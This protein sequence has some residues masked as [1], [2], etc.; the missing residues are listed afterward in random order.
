VTNP[1]KTQAIAK[2]MTKHTIL[3]I[4]R[5]TFVAVNAVRRGLAGNVSDIIVVSVV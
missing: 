1:V 2:C 3:A 4:V 5:L